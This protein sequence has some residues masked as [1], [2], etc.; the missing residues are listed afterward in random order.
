M[1]RVGLPFRIGPK[2]VSIS[3]TDG[4]REFIR[5]RYRQSV[6]RNDGVDRMD[7][8]QRK[9]QAPN[10]EDSVTHRALMGVNVQN[11]FST[12]S[13]ARFLKWPPIS[14]EVNSSPKAAPSHTS[15]AFSNMKSF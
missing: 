11:S 10:I 15:S 3:A 2:R 13:F 8:E 1:T 9:T 6:V 14:K 5:T 7:A 4:R 12:V